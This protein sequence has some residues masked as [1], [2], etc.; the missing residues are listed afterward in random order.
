MKFL[1]NLALLTPLLTHLTQ[2]QSDITFL[3]PEDSSDVASPQKFAD[4]PVF[5]IGERKK[6]RWTETNET[7]SIVLYQ[8]RPDDQFE[9]VFRMSYLIR[10][11]ARCFCSGHVSDSISR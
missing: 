4:N 1:R 7:I 9:Y 5:K 8:E 6:L 10:A 3:S 2:A 11:V